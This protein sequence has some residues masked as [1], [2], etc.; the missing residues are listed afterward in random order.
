LAARA[1]CCEVKALKSVDFPTFGNPTIP[2]RNIFDKFLTNKNFAQRRNLCFI[3]CRPYRQSY[4]DSA[5]RP[6]IVVQENNYFLRIERR[7][8]NVSQVDYLVQKQKIE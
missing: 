2:A 8:K 6:N 1:A 7:F 4:G 3:K 5:S